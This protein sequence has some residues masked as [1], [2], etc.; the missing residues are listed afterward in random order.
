[1]VAIT[2]TNLGGVTMVSFA[3][4]PATFSVNGA[5]TQI[6][7]TVPAGAGSGPIAVTSPGGTATATVPFTSTAATGPAPASSSSGSTT[8]C[9]QGLF[10]ALLGLVPGVIRLMRLRER[11]IPADDQ[12]GP[13]DC[14]R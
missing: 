2:G 12:H 8:R 11:T 9:G 3:G 5:G 6:M 7:A 1:V 10:M 14:H 4:M 13:H